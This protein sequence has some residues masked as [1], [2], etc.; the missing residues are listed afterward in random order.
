[1]K[2]SLFWG[3]ILLGTVVM[4]ATHVGAVVVPHVLLLDCGDS[5]SSYRPPTGKVFIIEHIMFNDE[6]LNSEQLMAVEL[7]PD[8][9]QQSRWISTMPFSAT[10]NTLARPIKVPHTITIA[11]NTRVNIPYESD[12]KCF[13]FGMLVDEA[14]LYAAVPSEI[15]EFDRE[16]TSS[17]VGSIALASPR[18]SI[19]K[20]ESSADLLNWQSAANASIMQQSSPH[21]REF[22]V[23]PTGQP[24]ESSTFWRAKARARSSG[25]AALTNAAPAPK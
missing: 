19:V 21:Q 20:M 11:V 5:D 7:I 1:V 25:G 22:A 18:P 9:T 14:D 24:G 10:W 12:Y 4:I 23:D 16:S 17:L 3:Q 6:W 2:R 8:G 15:I 13:I